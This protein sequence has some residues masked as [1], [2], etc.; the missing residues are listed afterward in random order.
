MWA[1]L[2]PE[3]KARFSTAGEDNTSISRTDRWKAGIEI[4]NEYPI[5]GIGYN[6]WNSY[7][8]PLSHNIFIEAWSELGYTGL[9]AF[10]LLIAGTFRIN[11]QTRK[12]LRAAQ[13]PTPFMRHMAYGLDGALI[14]YLVSG[15]FVTVLYYPYFWVNLSMTVAL[16][17]TARGEVERARRAHRLAEHVISGAPHL[18]TRT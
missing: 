7:Y 10:L 9:V 11:Y 8:G 5:L 4:A 16:H 12:L 13:A 3:Q 17:V 2:P 14:G 6:N 1:V 18:S 15:F